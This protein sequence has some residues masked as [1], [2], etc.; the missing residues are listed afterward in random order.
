MSLYKYLG[1]H[2][3]NLVGDSIEEIAQSIDVGLPYAQV[4][5]ALRVFLQLKLVEFASG[6]LSVIRG[7]KTQLTNSELYNFISGI[8]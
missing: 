4:Y 6:R 2:A 7:V 1:T 8:K 3:Y 5:F